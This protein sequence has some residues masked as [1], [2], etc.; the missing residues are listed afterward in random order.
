M[1][2]CQ[3]NLIVK[4]KTEEEC[5]QQPGQEDLVLLRDTYLRLAGNNADKKAPGF[6]QQT[7]CLWSYGARRADKDWRKNTEI[8]F[9]GLPLPKDS[10]TNKDGKPTDVDKELHNALGKVEDWRDQCS[11]SSEQVVSCDVSCRAGPARI[12]TAQPLV[13]S[14]SEISAASAG[15]GESSN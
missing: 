9:A 1:A 7:A 8:R 15:Y 14:P 13:T 5:A 3:T 4:A 12:V 2:A 10:L 6:C 11:K